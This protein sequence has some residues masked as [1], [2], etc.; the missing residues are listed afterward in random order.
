[1]VDLEKPGFLVRKG[2]PSNAQGEE[3]NT[4]SKED[5]SHRCIDATVLYHGTA[6]IR[7][8]LSEKG[9]EEAAVLEIGEK[10]ARAERSTGHS[11]RRE[12][13]HNC[14]MWHGGK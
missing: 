14:M 6:L 8:L 3:I 12:K 10:R 5:G 7:S 1:M 13:P 4:A 11:M 9:G 2:S